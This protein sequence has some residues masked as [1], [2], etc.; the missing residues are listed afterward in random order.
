MTSNEE[1]YYKSC[2]FIHARYNCTRFN[3]SATH[4]K[5][6]FH[7]SINV[8]NKC[9]IPSRY[10]IIR[11]LERRPINIFFVGDSHVQQIFESILCTF[12]DHVKDILLYERADKTVKTQTPGLTKE[13]AFGRTLLESNVTFNATSAIETNNSSSVLL[14]SLLNIAEQE[15]PAQNATPAPSTPDPVPDTDTI[16]NNIKKELEVFDRNVYSNYDSSPECHTIAY[17]DYT[18]FGLDEIIAKN[19]TGECTLSHVAGQVSCAKIYAVSYSNPLAYSWF[20]FSYVRP[21]KLHDAINFALNHSISMLN[22]TINRFDVVVANTY[23]S[24]SALSKYLKERLYR[25]RVLAVPKWPFGNQTNKVLHNHTITNTYIDNYDEYLKNSENTKR[26]C[27]TFNWANVNGVDK[28]NSLDFTRL[29]YQ[30]NLDSKSSIYPLTYYENGTNHICQVDQF[31][32]NNC[33][34]KDFK[35]C[36][37]RICNEESH[38]CMPGPTDAFSMVVLAAAL[39]HVDHNGQF[40]VTN[41]KNTTFNINGV[42][43]KNN[44]TAISSNIT[45]IGDTQVHSIKFKL[46]PTYLFVIGLIMGFWANYIFI[47]L[48]KI[49]KRRT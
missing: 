17:E 4:F 11:I 26:F 2:K 9:R 8:R 24:G 32:P 40:V 44:H 13:S 33:E 29:I 43:P 23:V 7:Q 19:L 31:S 21:L 35:V 14:P 42:F 36:D 37:K 10:S 27:N 5:I 12:Q 41:Y 38:F 49:F 22:T 15:S 6:D 20:C 34:G 25:G 16:I 39:S 3:N 45:Q 28:C 47:K 46:S 1:P 18:K 48:R 30:R